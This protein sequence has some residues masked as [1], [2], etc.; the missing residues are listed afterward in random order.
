MAEMHPRQGL[1]LEGPE[2]FQLC[3]SESAYLLDGKLGIAAG[4]I[5]QRL[6]RGT[7]FFFAD[8]K[9]CDLDVVKAGRI[10]RQGLV[11]PLSHLGNDA[12][13]GTG[14]FVSC[15][16]RLRLGLLEVVNPGF[17][18]RASCHVVLSAV[19]CHAGRDSVQKW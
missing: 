5:V 7:L 3:R 13:H 1:D 8:F 17:V 9:A 11:P 15:A 18:K 4:L 6:D 2:R 12:G 10:V 14:Q 19:I 16:L